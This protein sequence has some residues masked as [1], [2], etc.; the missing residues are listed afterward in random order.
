MGDLVIGHQ[1]SFDGLDV[2][3]G[4]FEPLQDR[5]F[6]VAGRAR[7]ATDPIALGDV[8]R[9]LENLF[10]GCPASVKQC[11]FRFGKGLLAGLASVTLPTGF[12][13]TKLDYVSR[14]VRL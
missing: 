13:V 7:Q 1:H 8:G 10:N 4:F 9:D 2:L 11:P 3:G 14:V 6:F 5:V 12:G